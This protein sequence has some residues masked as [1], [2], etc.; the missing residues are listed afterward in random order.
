MWDVHPLARLAAPP[1]NRYTAKNLMDKTELT[2]CMNDTKWEE[3]RLAMYGLGEHSPQWRT[4]DVKNDYL[5]DWQ[6]EWFYHFEQ[7]GFDT[8]YWVEIRAESAEQKQRILSLLKEIHV[9]GE[10]TELGF[11]VY[12]YITP[13]KSI[14]YL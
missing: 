6:G 5:C 1:R 14:N 7:G 10:E 12:G 2:S 8:I 11:K 13:G 9:P 4:K 3:L